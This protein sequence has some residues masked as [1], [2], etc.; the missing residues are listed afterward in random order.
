M[1]RF[2]F[3]NVPPLPCPGCGARQFGDH[4]IQS[5]RVGWGL[6]VAQVPIPRF[7]YAIGD[8]IRWR[9]CL[10]GTIHPWTFFRDISV[11]IGDPRITDVVVLDDWPARRCPTCG[12]HIGGGAVHIT[13]GRITEARLFVDGEFG[14]D[15]LVDT[16]VMRPDGSIEPLPE[17]DSYGRA[18]AA[19]GPLEAIESIPKAVVA[20]LLPPPS[21]HFH[22]RSSLPPTW[23]PVVAQW[24]SAHGTGTVWAGALGTEVLIAP[25]G[26]GEFAESHGGGTFLSG[27]PG[28]E[29][30]AVVM[31]HWRTAAELILARGGEDA[32]IG[33]LADELRGLVDRLAPELAHAYVSVEP[34]FASVVTYSQLSDESVFCDDGTYRPR[35]MVSEACDEVVLDAYHHQVLG[36]GHLARLGGPPA[37]SRTLAAGRVSIT[38]G[39][40]RT[41]SPRPPPGRR[42]ASKAGRCFDR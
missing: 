8:R 13:G 3:C 6:A 16:F 37:G 9:T 7:D 5:L 12:T 17:P 25:R 23:T 18:T 38:L 19:C 26:V 42:G 24:L 34:T 15:E 40:P 1:P 4:S 31:R 28:S 30:R 21:R 14:D 2:A 36:P 27:D 22:R 10:E 33:A 32:D 41:G 39:S 35:F 29:A 20:V 11:N